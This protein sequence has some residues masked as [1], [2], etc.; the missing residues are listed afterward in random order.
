MKIQ[1][2]GK[3]QTQFLH[4]AFTAVTTV[5][6]GKRRDHVSYLWMFAVRS[7]VGSRDQKMLIL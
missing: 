5:H 6:I 4:I 7:A 1:I 3:I 2:A